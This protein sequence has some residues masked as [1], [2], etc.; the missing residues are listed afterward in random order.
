[1]ANQQRKRH[2]LVFWTGRRLALAFTAW[3]DYAIRKQLTGDKLQRAAA[4]WSK[5]AL[6][7]A[8]YGWIE[9]EAPTMLLRPHGAHLPAGQLCLWRNGLSDSCPALEQAPVASACQQRTW[10]HLNMVA[11]AEMQTA[12]RHL[13]FVLRPRP[14]GRP[15]SKIQ[16]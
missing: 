16:A 15:M 7:A 8:F 3:Q 11:R 13:V 1:M 6:A 9:G 12:P 2:A 4:L 10:Q 5:Q 14:L